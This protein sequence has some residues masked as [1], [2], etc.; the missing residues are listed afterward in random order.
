MTVEIFSSGF[1]IGNILHVQKNDCQFLV[2][3]CKMASQNVQL[4][5]AILVVAAI[6]VGQRR[7]KD[8]VS[9]CKTFKGWQAW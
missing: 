4:Q 3:V 7:E 8:Q 9:V 1:T 2:S 6:L 5:L